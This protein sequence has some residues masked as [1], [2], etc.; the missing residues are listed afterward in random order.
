MH[1]TDMNR[2][3]FL[4]T[5][6]LAAATAAGAIAVQVGAVALD[7]SR[8]WAMATTV[9]DDRE[10]RTL[11]AM[12]RHLFPHDELGDR[13][14]AAA[15]EALDAQAAADPAFAERLRSGIAELDAAMGIPFVDLSAG[16]QL[17]LLEDIE[18]SEFFEAVRGATMAALYNNEV[19]AR[20][21]GYEG[22]SVEYGGYIERG[23]NDIGWLPRLPD[24]RA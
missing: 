5:T 18:G 12:A 16:N 24:S 20:E 22:S 10:A 19:V 4:Q 14:Y 23:F 8:A 13:Y 11:L 1:G 9:L 3:R 7:P 21:F 2:R 15:V 6:S 17:Q